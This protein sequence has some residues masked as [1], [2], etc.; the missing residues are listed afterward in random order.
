MENIRN[1]IVR[2]DPF[3]RT[4]IEIDMGRWGGQGKKGY[5]YSKRKLNKA[6]Q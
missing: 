4:K 2:T 1:K 6:T 3:P 5:K